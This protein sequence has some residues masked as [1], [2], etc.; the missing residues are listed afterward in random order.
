MFKKATLIHELCHRLLVDNDFYFFDTINRSEDIHKAIDLIL[1]DIWIDILGKSGADESKE[2][3]M[4]Y[5]IQE[6]KNAWEWAFSFDKEARQQ[7]FK[8]LTNKYANQPKTNRKG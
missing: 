4:S 1:Y 3:E 8:E 7:K 6:Y 5:T 2:K